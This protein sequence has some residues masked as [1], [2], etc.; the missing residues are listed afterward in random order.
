M[1]SGPGR[2]YYWDDRAL[3]VGPGAAGTRHA[4]HAVQVCVGLSGPVRL[5]AG[6][7]DRW[8]S[9]EG[10]IIP[11]NQPHESDEPVTLIATFWIEPDAPEARLLDAP[12]GKLPIRAIARTDLARIVPLL[13]ACGR[14]RCDAARAA[15][16]LDR[17]TRILGRVQPPLPGLDPRIARAREIL[18]AAPDRH[19]ALDQ[20]AAA[21]AL[22]PSRLAHL[23]KSG[24]RTPARR[25]LL[26]LRLRDAIIELARGASVT[27]AAH[28]AGFADSPH[29]ARTFR[30][31]L[32]FTPTTALRRSRFVQD[33]PS[34]RA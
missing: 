12:S 18:A 22:S 8:R 31:M 16:L 7:G 10:A 3:Y 5:R 17:A 30:R 11:S 20:V 19:V 9:Y 29:L 27:E 1:E 4:H 28:A 14:E 32:G 6:T 34:R 24:L 33:T 13:R 2:F 25:Y 21:V 26:W 15:A 23:L